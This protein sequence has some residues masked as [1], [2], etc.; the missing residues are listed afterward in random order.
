MSLLRTKNINVGT[1]L[2]F[3]G[4]HP[5]EGM[6]FIYG[7][8]EFSLERGDV[9]KV[10]DINRDRE[11]D[12]PW[13]KVTVA[14]L[15]GKFCGRIGTVGIDFSSRLQRSWQALTQTGSM[16]PVRAP[17]RGA[18]SSSRYSIVVG[19]SVDDEAPT[20]PAPTMEVKRGKSNRNS[21]CA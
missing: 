6:T 2:A 13:A 9:V 15:K 10:I 19:K 1:V 11:G 17:V 8:A 12:T 14:V 7:P 5:E 18:P 16:A 20:T 4:V 21:K 3:T